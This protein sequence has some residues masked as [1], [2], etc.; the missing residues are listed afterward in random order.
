VIES[1]TGQSLNMYTTQKLKNPT[2]MTGAFVPV[3]YNQVY[4]SNARSM[5]RFGL[6]ILN[7]GNWNGSQLMTDTTY[8]KQMVQTSQLLNEAYGYLW[9]LNGKSSYRLPAT[10][11][12]FNGPLCPSAPSDMIAAMGK[13]GQ[14]LNVVPGENLVWVRMGNSPDNLP[15]PFLLNDR[16]WSYVR[17][18]GCQ[19]L[20]LSEHGAAET[21][22][23]LFPNPAGTILNI[24]AAEEMSGLEILSVQGSL[25]RTEALKGHARRM[26]VADLAPGLYGIRITLSGGRQW[27]GKFARE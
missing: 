2:G 24:Q 9:W 26:S 5:A 25:L 27:T 7:K 4:F 21:F 19:P 8:F 23:R 12:L 10:Q 14:F 22:V 1:A 16:I 18:L 3:G 11:L 6:L 20:G 17:E 13:D 15:V